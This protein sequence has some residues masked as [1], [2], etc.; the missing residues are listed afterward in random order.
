[1]SLANCTICGKI[2]V[3]ES[4]SFCKSCLEEKKEDIETVKNYLRNHANP[5]LMEVHTMTGVPVQTIQKLIK[6]GIISRM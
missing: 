5:N 1:L 4:T 6:E 3:N 2:I